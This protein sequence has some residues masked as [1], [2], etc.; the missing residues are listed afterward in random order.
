[1]AEAFVGTSIFVS[2]VGRAVTAGEARRRVERCVWVMTEVWGYARRAC[3]QIAD[4]VVS[5]RL[6]CSTAIS[7]A[8]V[9]RKFDA[10]G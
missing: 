8:S 9:H 5:S 4:L 7:F 1:M 10:L 2:G 3:R 6:A